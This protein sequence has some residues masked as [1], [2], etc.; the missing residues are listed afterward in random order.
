MSVM[1]DSYK[2]GHFIQY[3]EAQKM[4][5]YGE[6]R[7][8]FNNDKTDNRFVFYGIRYFVENYLSHRWTQQ[9]I[10]SADKFFSTHN[11]G[12][13]PYPWPK[14]LMQAMITENNGYFPVKLQALPEGTCAHIHVPVFVITAEGKW[15]RLVTFL[16]TILTHLWY[17]TTVATLSRRTR[18]LVDVAFDTSVDPELD[19][20]RTSRLHD[21]GFRG[22][23]C[24]EQSIIGG[25]SHLL[26]FE[27]TDTM[28]AAYYAQFHLNGG[29]PVASSIPATEH[30]VMTAWPTEVHAIRKM[31][32]EFGGDNCL[33]ATVMDSYDYTNALETILP[34]MHKEKVAKGKSVWVLRPDSGNPTEV[35]LQALHAA[36]KVAGHTVNSKGFKVVNGLSALQGDGIGY[37]QIKDILEK[38]IAEGWSAS[39]VVFG[40]GGGLLQKVNRD[41]MSF[42]TKLSFIR[43]ADGTN[44]NVMKKPKT[45]G[46]KCSLPG[47]LKVV[48]LDGIPTV[49]PAKEGENDPNDILQ[50]V[51]DMGP[52]P[53][54]VWEDFD[55]LRKRVSTE[56]KA[57]PRVHDPIHKDLYQVIQEWIK[58]FEE[59]YDS[60]MKVSESEGPK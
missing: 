52:V 17:P 16:E 38:V 42:A 19:F 32:Q 21:F 13:L 15:S 12:G 41:T 10:D 11:A 46:G 8:P 60:R 22:C 7:A 28:S 31:I 2:A 36:D 30:S 5:A 25:T 56:W 1:T 29:K 4:I 48:R 43:Y 34:V 59:N 53:N 40:M 20:L 58:D 35:I 23:T 51:W 55:S 27:G 33:F 49:I 3:P 45:D 57:L 44:R 26:N 6:F 18:E 14:D 50:T 54:L 47:M 37:A 24:V 39:N 9:E